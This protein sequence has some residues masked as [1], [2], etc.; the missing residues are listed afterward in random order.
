[1]TVRTARAFLCA[2]LDRIERAI[3]IA[4]VAAARPLAE[5]D[6]VLATPAL[7]GRAW[8]RRPSGTRHRPGCGAALGALP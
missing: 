7:T 4:L 6:V 8:R 1:V 2:K 3:V 5:R